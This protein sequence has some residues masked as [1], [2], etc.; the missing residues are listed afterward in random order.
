[1]AAQVP[2]YFDYLIDGF[3][4]AHA[5]RHVHLGYWDQPPP[6]T[7]PCSQQEFESAQARLTD[8]VVDLAQLHDGCQLLDVG[9][10][11]GGT[12]E[13]VAKRSG[14]QMTGLNIDARQLEICRTLPIGSSSLSLVLADACALPF[15]PESFKRI[16]C[17]E[18]MFHFASREIFLQQA[19]SALVSGG[20]LVV[21]DILLQAPAP[22]AAL[23]RKIAET[24]IRREY[25][26]WPEPWIEAGAL[27]DA[28]RRA[29]LQLEQRVDITKQT[30]P[31]YRVTAPQGDDRLP[32]NPGAG[33][34]LRWLHA[35]GHLSYL[36]MSFV[37][38]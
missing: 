15:R 12:L 4:S 36:C 2:A 10:G 27:V 30:L 23:S 5:S 3:R 21:S 28:A 34:V 11:F 31:T 32:R 24:A 17:V 14:I 35:T 20:R 25:G 13:V 33:S 6:L 8:I 38:A 1:M 9:C 16:F 37:K 18:A 29:G 26:P 7:A 22:N 19:A